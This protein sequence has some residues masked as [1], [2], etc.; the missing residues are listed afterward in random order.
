MENN[1][2]LSD[3]NSSK[4]E[5]INHEYFFEKIDNIKEMQN[6][7]SIIINDTFENAFNSIFIEN[8]EQK[9]ILIQETINENPL[10]KPCP[11]EVVVCNF[12]EE[13]DKYFPF[14]KGVGL[15]KTLEKMGYVL[16][17]EKSG[18]ISLSAVSNHSKFRTTDYFTNKKG[19]IKKQKK[20]RKFKPDDIRKKIK[21]KFHK[22]IKNV[23]NKKLLKAKSKKLFDFFPQSFITNITIKANNQALN[24]TYEKLIEQDYISKQKIKKDIDQEKTTRNREVLNYLNENLEIS[25][26]SEFERIRTMKYSDILRAYFISSEFE[27]SLIDL[28][29]KRE[30]IDYIEEYISKAK[31]YVDFFSYNKKLKNNNN[32]IKIPCDDS[33]EEE[34]EGEE[35]DRGAYE[36]S[37]EYE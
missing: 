16:K 9:P 20:K 27:Q 5:M 24:L 14:T 2:F 6:H 29:N 17:D 18:K 23:I 8:E 13:N 35:D 3:D 37:Y 32:I 22:N 7:N 4:N 31:T 33:E 36:H 25:K 1:P 15:E 28:Y 10:I 26:N 34:G 30:K 11:D 21:A 19:I 12:K